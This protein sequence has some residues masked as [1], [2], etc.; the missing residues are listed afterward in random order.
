MILSCA[1]IIV[2]VKIVGQKLYLGLK[3]KVQGKKLVK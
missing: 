1:Y 3:N 2:A